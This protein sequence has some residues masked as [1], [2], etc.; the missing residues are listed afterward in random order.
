[1]GSSQKKKKDSWREE[2]KIRLPDRKQKVRL[3]I[4]SSPDI[5][6]I[7]VAQGNQVSVVFKSGILSWN[8][9][10]TASL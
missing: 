4:I 2:S 10:Q 7:R 9:I 5:E 3:D 6:P 1:L 8:N